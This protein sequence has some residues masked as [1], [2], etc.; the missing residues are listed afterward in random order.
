MTNSPAQG[1]W[2]PDSCTLPTVEQPIRVAEFDR[3]FA[4]AV[5]SI[6]RPGPQRLELVLTGDTEQA[7]R[8]LA[9]RESSCCSFFTFDFA[10]TTEGPVMVVGVPAAYI[11]VL[12]A[13]AARVQAGIGDGR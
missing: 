11:E 9:G 2:V 13:F 8:D 7:A 10:T 6:R 3:L 5:R 4:D 1:D 12:D